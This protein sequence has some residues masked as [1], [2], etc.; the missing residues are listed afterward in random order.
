MP[1]CSLCL[2]FGGYFVVAKKIS[3]VSEV[4]FQVRFDVSGLQEFSEFL[5][6][7]I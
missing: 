6:I 3:M 5:F 2:F 4:F 7:I 1:N